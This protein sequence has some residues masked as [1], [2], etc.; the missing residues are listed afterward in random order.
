MIAG[1]RRGMGRTI[2]DHMRAQTC[3]HVCARVHLGA[4]TRAHVGAWW[5]G[6][7]LLLGSFACLCPGPLHRGAR[8]Y[9]KRARLRFA[10]PFLVK[11]DLWL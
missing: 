7:S 3:R 6:D 4:R 2:R 1:Y 10:G 5:K 8:E 9:K 11:V